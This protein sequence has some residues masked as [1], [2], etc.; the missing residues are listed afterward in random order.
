MVVCKLGH[1]YNKENI[2]KGLLEKSLPHAFRHIKKLKDV[3]V[4]NVVW[5][6]NTD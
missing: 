4:G 6:D 3:K 1:L 5:K 2:L